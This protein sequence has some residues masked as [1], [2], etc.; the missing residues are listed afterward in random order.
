MIASKSRTALRLAPSRRST[1]SRRADVDRGYR[2][3]QGF[4]LEMYM[5]TRLASKS[6][7]AFV[8]TKGK[9]KF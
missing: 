8:E 2:F 3:E 4:T 7:D 5:S 1:A 6:R 9:A